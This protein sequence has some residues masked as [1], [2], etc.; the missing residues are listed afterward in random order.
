MVK[1]TATAEA[2]VGKYAIEVAGTAKFNAVPVTAKSILN[3]EVVAAAETEE[4]K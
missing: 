3:V 2:T 1:L 4:T